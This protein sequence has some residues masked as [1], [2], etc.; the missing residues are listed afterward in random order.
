MHPSSPSADFIFRCIFTALLRQSRFFVARFPG[1]PE[2]L[3]DLCSS[4]ACRAQPCQR[5]TPVLQALILFSDASTALLRQS[6]FLL[7]NNLKY[8]PLR[9]GYKSRNYY[10][11][12]WPR[13]ACGRFR[14]TFSR[15][16]HNGKQPFLLQCNRFRRK[17]ALQ[18]P[19][20]A[21]TF[22]VK[23]GYRKVRRLS[24]TPK[25]K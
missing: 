24:C 1:E 3:I 25:F 14:A 2:A 13:N 4:I 11:Y 19:L 16:G 22:P 12:L 5:C 6:R 17:R 23:K 15:L 9:S 21:T 8:P 10:F 18:L 20:S 7:Q